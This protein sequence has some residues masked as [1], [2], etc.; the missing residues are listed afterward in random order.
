MPTKSKRQSADLVESPKATAPAEKTSPPPAG[1]M[2][3]VT[4]TRREFTEPI[5]PVAPPVEIPAGDLFDPDEDP[6]AAFLDEL[7]ES[8]QEFILRVERLPA[9]PTDPR[10][11]V[12]A[13]REFCGQMSFDSVVAV[14]YLT[15]VQQLYG[16]GRYQFELR[17]SNGRIVPGGRWTRQIAGVRDA[18]APV[19]QAAPVQGAPAPQHVGGPP[20][21]APDPMREFRSRLAEFKSLHE[22]FRDLYPPAPPMQQH[23][24]DPEVAAQIAESKGKLEMLEKVMASGN[25]DLAER[26]LDK[27]IGGDDNSGWAGVIQSL[28]ETFGPVVAP[29]AQMLMQRAMVSGA[30]GFSSGPVP[31]EVR[32]IGPA[33]AA[34]DFSPAPPVITAQPQGPVGVPL[35]P[36]QKVSRLLARIVTDANNGMTQAGV[37]EDLIDLDRDQNLRQDPQ[38]TGILIHLLTQPVDQVC[39]AFPPLN[40]PIGQ[41]WLAELQR[42]YRDRMNGEGNNG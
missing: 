36:V 39:A 40:T 18:G 10:T 28:I 41:A 25:K 2:R 27:F 12:K 42:Q 21:P 24:M 1:Q 19:V 33:P 15:S 4:N 11:G 23:T 22:I 30:A 20:V 29:L 26:L 34:S 9:Y 14:S 7:E 5:A 38:A 37:I 3:V 32:G 31:A 13:D 6:M 8:Q 17:R 35:S 16:P